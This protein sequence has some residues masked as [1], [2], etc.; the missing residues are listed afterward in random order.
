MLLSMPPICIKQSVQFSNSRRTMRSDTDLCGG[1]VAAQTHVA[2]PKTELLRKTCFPQK[3]C[4]QL[5]QW[6][7]ITLGPPGP[8]YSQGV[9]TFQNHMPAA[10]ESTQVLR[11]SA[12]LSLKP[13]WCDKTRAHDGGGFAPRGSEAA[14]VKRGAAHMRLRCKQPQLRQ[15]PHHT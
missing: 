3:R 9:A 2:R 12:A 15:L 6:L 14:H 10:A 11:V 5:T 7:G 1:L 13:F 4:T 8:W